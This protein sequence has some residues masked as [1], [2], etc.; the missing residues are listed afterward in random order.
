MV[1]LLSSTISSIAN[2]PTKNN[3]Q[4]AI[5]CSGRT[6]G[7][8]NISTSSNLRPRIL[9]ACEIAFS[10]L[11]KLV[12]SFEKPLCSNLIQSRETSPE[13]SSKTLFL[14]FVIRK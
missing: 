10:F 14:I 7:I 9:A 3:V 2:F 5:W 11:P 4:E 12:S 13:S 1:L 8:I 6:K